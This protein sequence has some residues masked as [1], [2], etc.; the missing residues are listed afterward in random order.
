MRI[1]MCGTGG[2]G[3]KNFDQTV[4]NPVDLRQYAD[5]LTF[6][7]RQLLEAKHGQSALARLSS[8]S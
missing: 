6:T 7:Q 5:T 8:I 4:R 3:Q 2:A 1:L